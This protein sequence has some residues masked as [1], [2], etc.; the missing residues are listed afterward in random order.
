MVLEGIIVALIFGVIVF[1]LN[2][3]GVT[4]FEAVMWA[5]GILGFIWFLIR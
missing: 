2:G 3:V 1:F 4:G 5:I